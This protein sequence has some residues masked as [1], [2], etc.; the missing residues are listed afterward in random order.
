MRRGLDPRL[1]LD[2][3]P[4]EQC[5]AGEN[6]TVISILDVPAYAVLGMTRGMK[7]FDGD[8]L[9]D[10]ECLTVLGRGGHGSTVFTTNDLEI[11]ELGPL[12]RL[13]NDIESILS[14]HTMRSFPPA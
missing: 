7:R 3:T 10:L 6:S 14:L 9:T 2:L 4:N 1:G 13:S 5:V 12:P 8:T 11:F